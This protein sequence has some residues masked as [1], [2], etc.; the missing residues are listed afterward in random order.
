MLLNFECGTLVGYYLKHMVI[1]QHILVIM[2]SNKLGLT[3][4]NLTLEDSDDCVIII[5]INI[6]DLDPRSRLITDNTGLEATSF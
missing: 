1:S 6:L 3:Y 4:L 5:I 2:P